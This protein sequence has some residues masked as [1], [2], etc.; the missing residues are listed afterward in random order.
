M[1][2]NR[3]AFLREIEATSKGD[4]WPIITLRQV[5]SDLIHRVRKVPETH[6]VGDGLI[7]GTPGLV[8]AVQT[9]DCLPVLLVDPKRKAVGAFHAGWRGTLKRIV[10]KGV[11]EIRKEFGSEP[12][13]LVAALGPAIHA[14]CY[15]VGKEVKEKFESQ[16]AYAPELFREVKES[17]EDHEKYPLLFLTAKPPG[18]SELPVKL[19]LDLVEAYRRHLLEAGVPAKNIEASPMCTSC[20]VDLLF[21]HRRE[22][23]VTGRMMGAIAIRP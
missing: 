15:Q 17:N 11:G 6:P 2:R 21:S 13:N 5:H 23:G 8:I 18:H 14:C 3:A 1:E 20:V 4:L 9:A 16:F 12:Q 10:Q 7:T 22:K 19:F